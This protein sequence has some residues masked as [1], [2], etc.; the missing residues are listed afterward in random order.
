MASVTPRG[1]RRGKRLM[2]EMNLD[3][4]GDALK[5]KYRDASITGAI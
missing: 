5:A 1:G 3:W 2:A 4:K